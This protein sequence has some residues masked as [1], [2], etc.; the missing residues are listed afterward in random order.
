MTAYAALLKSVNLAGKKKVAMADLRDL[1][2]RLGYGA[3]RTLLQSGNLVFTAKLTAAKLE[4]KLEEAI[5]DELGVETAVMVR[6]AASLAEVIARD[7]MPDAA[8]DDPGHLVALFSKS[9]VSVE[10][11]SRLVAA[12]KGREVVKAV[13]SVVYAHYVDGIGESKLTNA[14]IERALGV[15]VTGR[16]WNTVLKLDAALKDL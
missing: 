6:D 7:P 15:A 13:G 9:A 12:I 1:A 16:N 2:E 14:V 10:A 8:R 5:A 4:A 11:E 3:P